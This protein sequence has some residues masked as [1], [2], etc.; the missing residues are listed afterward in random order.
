VRPFVGAS[1]AR[2][3]NFLGRLKTLLILRERADRRL[4]PGRDLEIS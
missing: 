3:H 1:V 2:R 4:L